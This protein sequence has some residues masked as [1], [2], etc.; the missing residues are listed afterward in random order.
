MRPH[1]ARLLF[2]GTV[3]CLSTVV[4]LGVF[5]TKARAFD[6]QWYEEGK[7]RVGY[8]EPEVMAVVCGD[9]DPDASQRA[10]RALDPQADYLDRRGRVSFYRV[11]PGLDEKAVLAA[12]AAARAEG[13]GL[14]PL[15]MPGRMVLSGDVV[16]TFASAEARAAK[17]GLV[18]ER[19]LVYVRHF[20]FA[21]HMAQYRGDSPLDSL[22]A[23]NELVE[24]GL[25][26]SA[27]PDW[28]RFRELK[29]PAVGSAGGSGEGVGSGSGSVGGSGGS[30]GGGCSRGGYNLSRESGA[31][32]MADASLPFLFFVPAVV[33]ARR[34]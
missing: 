21:P 1:A 7:L 4:F 26:V 28:M 23:A 22:A 6:L 30:S 3:L 20:D 10:V 19:G 16:A 9:Q 13:C 24:A 11:V 17:A 31:G 33:F 18:A 8:A 27:T 14:S 2:A 29:L 32:P 5:T 34:R 12:G 15:V 25:V